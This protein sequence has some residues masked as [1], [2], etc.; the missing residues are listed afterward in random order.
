MTLETGE[1]QLLLEGALMAVGQNHFVSAKCILDAL[2][3]FRPGHESLDVARAVMLLSQR[4]PRECIDFIDQEGM[5]RHPENDLLLAF[6]GAALIQ[7]FRHEEAKRL[8]QGVQTS[9]DENAAGIARGLLA[10]MW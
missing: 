10:A 1:R 9:K 7:L 4:H 8:L 6:K 5:P 2:E 3:G